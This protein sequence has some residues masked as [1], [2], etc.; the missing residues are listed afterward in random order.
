[1][2][3][4]DNIFVVETKTQMR[5]A[6][7]AGAYPTYEE[8]RAN[9]FSIRIKGRDNYALNFNNG[10]HERDAIRITRRMTRMPS[11]TFSSTKPK[12]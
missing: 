7:L 12:E 2:L 5:Y 8:A 1:M 6:I 9:P 11:S 3:E 10:L 4:H